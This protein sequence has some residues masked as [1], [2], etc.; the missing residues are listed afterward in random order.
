MIKEP[1]KSI[2]LTAGFT[3]MVFFG[4]SFVIMGTLLP[5]LIEKFGLDD[6]SASSMVGLLPLGILLGSILFGPIIDRF[7]YKA[8]ILAAGLITIT[9]L[10]TLAFANTMAIARF[11]VFLIGFGGG[12]LNGLTNAL[13]SDI[14]GDKERASNLSILG[15]FYTAGAIILPLLFATL[16]KNFS[17]TAIVSATGIILIIPLIFFSLIIF[18]EAKLKQGVPFGKIISMAKEPALL[19]LSFILFFQSG[20]EGIS[21][22]WIPAFLES[23]HEISSKNAMFALTLV[24]AGIGIGRI[25]LG[26]LLRIMSKPIILLTSM[27]ISASG[28]II[29]TLSDATG[30]MLAGTFFLG[31]GLASTFPVILGEI[32]E[33]Y[34]DLSGTAF[35]FAL[36]VALTGNTLINLFVGVVTL[37]MLNYI[38]IASIMAIA[39]LYLI[40]LTLNKK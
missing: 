26:I 4:I 5:S 27:I 6:S 30:V 33:R 16:S 32:G 8:L 18:P 39:L 11:S 17:Y 29:L 40:F 22:N 24:I 9:G 38:M 28:V 36:V 14:S 2:V 10:E 20:L 3:G 37:N 19:I 12:V 13:V 21:N 23:T 31:M 15:V 1:N 7:G 35:S 25:I 34:K